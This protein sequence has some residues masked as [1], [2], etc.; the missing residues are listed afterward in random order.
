MA[1]QAAGSTWYPYSFLAPLQQNEPWLGSALRVVACLV[2]KL[3]LHR[4]PPERTAIMGFSQGACVT[5]EFVARHAP[6]YAGV[7]AFTDGLVGPPGTT[8]NYAGDLAGTP[9]LI[10]SS[11]VDPHVPSTACTNQPRSCAGWARKWMN[12]FTRGWGIPSTRTS[13][14][15][16]MRCSHPDS[17]RHGS[18]V[19]RYDSACDWATPG[20][21]EARCKR[22]L[23]AF[24]SPTFE[25]LSSGAIPSRSSI[26]ATRL[27]GPRRKSR[28]AVLI[29]CRS[30]RS[31]NISPSFHG[32]SV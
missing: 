11:D 24:L 15:R 17:L 28:F 29:E 2:E 12:A 18:Q 26:H 10:G 3:G 31:M 16:P 6:R 25:P 14:K 32:T 5:L 7:V 13:S 30:M 20:S 9:I 1:P 8:R 4:V 23:L 27:R 22:I 21:M 19:N